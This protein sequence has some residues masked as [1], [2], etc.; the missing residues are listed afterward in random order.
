MRKDTNL[1][2]HEV[3]AQMDILG[4][5]GVKDVS[6][7]AVVIQV[8]PAASFAALIDRDFGSQD[9]CV[10]MTPRPRTPTPVTMPELTPA[11]A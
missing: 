10:P 9:G 11:E 4:V 1:S 5:I 2:P 3:D 7:H 6:T 8:T